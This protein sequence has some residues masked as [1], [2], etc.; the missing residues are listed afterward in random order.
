P[1]VEAVRARPDACEGVPCRAAS[2]LE[3]RSRVCGGGCTQ[4]APQARFGSGAMRLC[5]RQ[6]ERRKR[7]LRD[8]LVGDEPALEARE[9]GLVLVQEVDEQ[10]DARRMVGDV[11]AL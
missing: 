5:E 6:L 10:V 7:R 3:R 11:R 1:G 4:L 9:L 2:L 8:G